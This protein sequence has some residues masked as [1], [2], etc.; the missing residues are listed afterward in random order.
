MKQHYT[1]R[2]LFTNDPELKPVSSH[3][4]HL[5][6]ESLQQELGLQES[7]QH[8]LNQKRHSLGWNLE[9]EKNSFSSCTW[10]AERCYQS[11]FKCPEKNCQLITFYYLVPLLLQILELVCCVIGSEKQLHSNVFLAFSRVI[12]FFSIGNSDRSPGQAAEAGPEL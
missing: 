10:N 11:N 3:S 4:S 6:R 5:I 9:G 8:E 7:R 1:A 12:L 2:R